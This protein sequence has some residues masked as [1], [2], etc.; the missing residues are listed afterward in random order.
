MKLLVILINLK[1]VGRNS[2]DFITKLSLQL[3]ILT[4]NLQITKTYISH[5]NT[6]SEALLR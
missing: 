3:I 6:F 4:R 1:F 2:F 5:R